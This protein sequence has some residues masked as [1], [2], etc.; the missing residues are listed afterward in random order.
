MATITTSRHGKILLAT[1]NEMV[2]LPLVLEE[3]AEATHGL[4]LLGWTLSVVLVD[5]S[6]SDEMHGALPEWRSRLGLELE[7]VNGR[8]SG[9]GAAVLQ[10]FRH[11]LDDPRTEFIVNLDADGQHDARQ[12]GDLLRIFSTTGAGITIGSRWT[13]GGRCYGLSIPR[14]IVSRCSSVALRMAGVP[15]HVKDP[16]TSFRVYRRDVAELITRE[17]LGFNGFSFFGAGIAV[18]AAHGM[19]V[20]ET[21]I[22]FRPRVGG[23]SNLSLRQTANAV[24]D[25]PRIRA[26]WSMVKRRE[27]AFR[28]VRS[29]P[30]T[31]TASRELEQLANT[32][33]ST[34]IILDTLAPHLGPRI[35]EIGAGLG[36][37]TSSLIDR[38]HEVTALEPDNGLFE[39][40][41]VR[42][43]VERAEKVNSTLESWSEFNGRVGTYDTVLYVN[44]LEHIQDDVSELQ[45]AA[46]VCRQHGNIV[47]F[48]PAAPSLY[49]SMDWISAHFRR[50]RVAELVAVA[51]LA[52]LE[53]VEC[54]YF[55]P[56]GKF[57]YWLMY[58]VLKLK[59]LGG[60]SVGVYDRLIVPLSASLPQ[61]VTRLSG[62]KNL[63]LV[64]RTN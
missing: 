60:G 42:A 11:C 46:Q 62:G 55:D 28:F 3:I 19:S 54:R 33:R 36:L 38:G 50:Y 49:G 59:T 8:R 15:R 16:T 6:D 14:R 13:K 31:Y 21:P 23:K 37:I 12:M 52:G 17:I 27:S 35:L 48:V 22:H 57:A 32:P 56:V 41:S 20:N 24:R 10:G 34:K 45:K 43:G 1:R 2:T 5:D 30:A 51:K 40:L 58:R 29:N 7:I 18:A 44:V 4:S 61:K 64:G 53:V 25:L 9:L 39:R 26:H 63:V 47:I